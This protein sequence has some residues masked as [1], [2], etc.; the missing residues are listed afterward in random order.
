MGS[1]YPDA[2]KRK[3]KDPEAGVP[4]AC[5]RD[6]QGT[7]EGAV[8]EMSSILWGHFEGWFLDRVKWRAIAGF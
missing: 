4:L 1:S 6:S 8:E 5:A 2:E 3:S 7:S